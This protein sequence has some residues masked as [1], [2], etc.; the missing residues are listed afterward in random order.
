MAVLQRDVV[1]EL[2]ADGVVV[3]DGSVRRH[4][5]HGIDPTEAGSAQRVGIEH[6]AEHVHLVDGLLDDEVAGEIAVDIPAGGGIPAD[7]SGAGDEIHLADLAALD[8]VHEAAEAGVVAPL[9]ADLK[10]LAALLDG[11]VDVLN[12]LGYRGEGLLAVAVL[13]GP[14]GGDGVLFMEVD[15]RRDDDRVDVFALEELFVVVDSDRVHGAARLDGSLPS[16][17]IDVANRPHLQVGHRDRVERASQ[18]RRASPADTDPAEA[19]GIVGAEDRGGRRRRKA[20]QERRRDGRAGRPG[21]K[22]AT[23]NVAIFRI[24]SASS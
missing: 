15:R 6:P 10:A 4:A 8:G 11:V 18:Q 16:R 21:D 20:G 23:G 7:V 22:L 3:H 9:E 13:V 24:H 12:A 1:R 5:L 14:D 19:N 17:R 2:V